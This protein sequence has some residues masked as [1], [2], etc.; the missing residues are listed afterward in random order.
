MAQPIDE[1]RF[2]ELKAQ[3]LAERKIAEALGVSHLILRRYVAQQK[4]KP[5][6]HQEVSEVLAISTPEVNESVHIPHELIAA[7]PELRE[8]L[9]WWRERKQFTDGVARDPEHETE[10]KTYHVQKRFIAA[11]ERAADLEHITIAEVVNRAFAQ[12]FATEQKGES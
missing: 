3:G 11:I 8:V 7:W 6:V 4:S 12:F 5:E 1:Q 9:T 2:Q 10:R